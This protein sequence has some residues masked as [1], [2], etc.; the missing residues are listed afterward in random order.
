MTISSIPHRIP[1]LFYYDCEA[2]Y[3]SAETANITEVCVSIDKKEPNDLPY[4]VGFVEKPENPNYTSPFQKPIPAGEERYPFKDVFENMIEFISQ[5]TKAHFKSILMGYNVIGWDEPVLRHNFDRNSMPHTPLSNWKFFD[6]AKLAHFLGFPLGTTQQQLETALRVKSAAANRHRAHADV[7]VVKEI[8]TKI[9]S[10]LKESVETTD[11]SE[12]SEFEGVT[13]QHILE[14]IFEKLDTAFL[15]ENGSEEEVAEV[16]KMYAPSLMPSQQ[17]LEIIAKIKAA[18]KLKRKDIVVLFD[19]ESTGLFP[20]MDKRKASHHNVVPRIVEFAAKILSP[21]SESEYQNETFSQ[22]VNP[23]IAIP[24]E[25]TK[26]HHITDD[27]VK[28]SP[29][30]GQVW[31]D[32]ESW[33]KTTHTFQRMLAER[34]EEGYEEPRVILVGYNNYRYD[35]S[36]L[37]QEL[38][39][40][41][42]DLKRE[43]DKGVKASWDALPLMS[44]LYTGLPESAKPPSN[45]LQDH[46]RFLSIP[47]NNAHRALG[48]VETLEKIIRHVCGSVDPSRLIIHAVSKKINLSSPGV[49]FKR[50]LAEMKKKERSEERLSQDLEEA[51]ESYTQSCQSHEDEDKA[52]ASKRR[53]VAVKNKTK[54]PLKA[55]LVDTQSASQPRTYI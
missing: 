32:F 10:I 15:Q 43:L 34:Q 39:R 54:P 14:K 17:A 55:F 37:L 13:K 4:F 7:K 36:L 27:I 20:E 48:D 22:L 28:D 16:L 9:L 19:I 26:V 6:L 52:P 38:L 3:I 35:N 8:W 46:A 29:T 1:N 47:E 45:K 2:D 12:Y 21:Y 50:I 24:P 11:L 5:H 44:T 49:G 30:M 53:R 33:V 31:T 41:G 42:I 51:I 23:G 40:V 18:E 25:A